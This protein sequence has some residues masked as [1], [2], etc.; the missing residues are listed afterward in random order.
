MAT[1]DER[2]RLAVLETKVEG[3]DS[4]ITE[5]KQ[6]IKDIKAMFIA[7]DDKYPT[8]REVA[9]MKWIIGII[10]IIIGYLWSK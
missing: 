7:L 4:K 3:I 2:E 1:K 6:D 5:V 9:V 10:L 8:R